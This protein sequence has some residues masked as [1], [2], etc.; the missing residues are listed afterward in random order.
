MT[1]ILVKNALESIHHTNQHRTVMRLLR[2]NS[3][4]E[5]R[6]SC[7]SNSTLRSLED[8]SS[9]SSSAI[10][11]VRANAPRAEEKASH[12]E[13]DDSASA[14]SAASARYRQAYHRG[15]AVQ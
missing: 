8:R 12:T 1:L 13:A 10:V 5:R 4:A 15:L 6:L 14:A 7:L 2:A 11:P 3:D 9:S